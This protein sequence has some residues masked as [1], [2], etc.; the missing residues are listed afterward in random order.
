M[1][2]RST[3]RYKRE[4]SRSSWAWSGCTATQPWAQ[5]SQQWQVKCEADERVERDRP[6]FLVKAFMTCLPVTGFD[7][8]NT[9]KPKWV[10]CKN[11]RLG[12]SY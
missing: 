1:K 8:S 12:V 10:E 9:R 7:E 11:Q 5:S 4:C 6:A 3:T 2:L